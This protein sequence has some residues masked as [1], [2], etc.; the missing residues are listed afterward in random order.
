MASATSNNRA[1]FSYVNY[2]DIKKLIDKGKIDVNDIIYTKDTHENIF[3]GSDLSIIPIQSKIYRFP[4]I[5]T[6]ENYLN[7]SIE[8]YE[9]QI[10]AILDNEVYT[11][12][13][14]NKNK[15]D[16]FYATKLSSDAGSVNYDNLGNRPISNLYG[17]IGN[18]II[19][20]ALSPGIYKIKGNYKITDND[21]TTYASSND[22]LFLINSK[23]D[24]LYIRKITAD[25]FINYTVDDSTIIS[26]SSTLTEDWI[27]EQN[28][29]TTEYVN[30]QIAALDFIKKDE[31]AQYVE[32]IV[33]DIIDDKLDERMDMKL[34]DSFST[35]EASDIEFLF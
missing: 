6:A 13:I 24:H 8:S 19:I 21:S 28:Y 33:S 26:T 1:K 12:Y 18:P 10:I 3:I 5:T 2:N 31:V 32:S 27:K 15:D 35:V 9:G 17:D 16:T 22:V 34:N 25:N 20:A 14:V 4:D 30:A 7:S 11:A 23:N 29:A